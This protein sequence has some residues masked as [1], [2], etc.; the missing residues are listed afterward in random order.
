[1]FL[2]CCFSNH[3]G[4]SLFCSFLSGFLLLFGRCFSIDVYCYTNVFTLFLFRG[5]LFGLWLF[6]S[7]RN[8]Q[9]VGAHIFSFDCNSRLNDFLILFNCFLE[10][11]FDFFIRCWLEFVLNFITGNNPIILFSDFILE[12]FFNIKRYILIR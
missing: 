5:Y 3:F 7:N 11:C 10:L 4:F 12:C 6:L 9:N 1:M 8:L 2:F